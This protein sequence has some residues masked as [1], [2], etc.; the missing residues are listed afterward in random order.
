MCMYLVSNTRVTGKQ[1]SF[2]E[3]FAHEVEPN[4][5]KRGSCS[6]THRFNNS[7]SSTYS[8]PGARGYREEMVCCQLAK[9]SHSQ[10]GAIETNNNNPKS[11]LRCDTQ[12]ALERAHMSC[13][14]NRKSQRPSPELLRTGLTEAPQG[15]YPAH[16][17]LAAHTPVSTL[18]Y[19]PR[20]RPP[21]RARCSHHKVS[22]KP[23][24]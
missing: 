16:Q 13:C 12:G 5:I 17:H 18:A 11:P 22:P 15:A 6:L 7:L 20:T 23:T 24:F 9:S 1:M 4:I 8:C 14:Q 3:D 21:A 19:K 2:H 10:S